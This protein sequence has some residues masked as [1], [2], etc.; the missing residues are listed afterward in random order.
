MSSRQGMQRTPHLVLCQQ[1]HGAAI[2]GKVQRTSAQISPAGEDDPPP[3]PP[4][5][6]R[7]D[8]RHMLAIDNKEIGGVACWSGPNKTVPRPLGNSWALVQNT[9]FN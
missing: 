1:L 5:R 7:C 3:L 4:A 2:H 9:Q 6:C 8:L